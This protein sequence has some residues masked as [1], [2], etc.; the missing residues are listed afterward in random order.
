[1]NKKFFYNPALIF[2]TSLLCHNSALGKDISVPRQPSPALSMSTT[3]SK[4]TND[5]N[6]EVNSMKTNSNNAITEYSLDNGMKVLFVERKSLPVVA[7]LVLYHVGSRNEAVGHTG[8]T[9]FL[10]HLMFKGSTNYDN[11]KGRSID[12][13]LKPIGGTNSATTWFD[14]TTYFFV[15]PSGYLDLCLDMEVD[16]MRGLLLRDDDRKSEMTVVRNE[17]ERGENDPQEVLVDQLFATAFRE[18]PYHHPTIGWRSDVENVPIERFRQFYNTFYWPNNATLIVVGNFDREQA[19]KLIKEKFSKIP[20]SPQPIPQVYTKEP[21][22]EGQ[23]RF[24]F[25]RGNDLE[26]IAVGFRVPEAKHQDS[27]A[28][29]VLE[30]ILGDGSSTASRLYTSMIKTGLASGAYAWHPQLRD[31]S[32]FIFCATANEGVSPDKLEQAVWAQVE[33]LQNEPVTE[34][35]LS[36]AKSIICKKLVLDA[37]DPLE[38]AE[39]IAESIAAVSWQW[40]ENYPANIQK[41]TAGDIMQVAKKYFKKRNSTIGY[42]LPDDRS[43]D[44]TTDTKAQTSGSNASAEASKQEVAT[45]TGNSSNATGPEFSENDLKV[46]EGIKLNFAQQASTYKLENGLTVNIFPIKGLGCATVY[47]IGKAGNYAALPESI[48]VTDMLSTII[49]KGT[50]KYTSEQIGDALEQMGTSLHFDSG[51]YFTDFSSDILTADLPRYLELL[52]QVLCHPTLS[53][54]EF[55]TAKKLLNSYI[56][57]NANDTALMAQ[58]ALSR[59][60][61]PPT[62]PSYRPTTQELQKQLKSLKLAHIQAFHKKQ[63]V[64]NNFGITVVGD[65]E[66]DAALA[67]IKQHFGSWHSGKDL[68]IETKQGPLLNTG[69]KIDVEIKDKANIDVLIGQAAYVDRGSSDYFA[70]QIANGVFGFDSFASRLA[71]LREKYGY[72]YRVFSRFKDPDFK[73]E[74]WYISFSVNPENA[75]KAISVAGNLLKEYYQKGM[76]QKELDQEKGRLIGN[77]LTSLRAPNA[78]AQRLG[79]AIALGLGISYLDSYVAKTKQVTLEQA[80]TAVRTYLNP[81][82]MV[83][84]VSGTISKSK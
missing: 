21:P 17:L 44:E 35:E 74:P 25:H 39:Q 38:Y 50:E 72:C 9:H 80:N 82:N 1:M 13:V 3:N 60:I 43:T 7:T 58:E 69:K 41:V 73:G 79:Q 11:Y 4:A 76:S 68:T 77:Y 57:D 59:S 49:T 48:L 40:G 20:A 33:K 64:P 10:E 26:R 65:I 18:H 47:G 30:S 2:L 15:V 31:P 22:Q 42:A 28:L 45:D 78:I 8:S 71:E 6:K 12:A 56:L 75:N 32:L 61:Y 23:R 37:A 27:Y 46:L 24:E 62:S 83:T 84:V 36:R 29:D 70:A 16:R 14:R 52:S 54:S 51:D 19:L 67:Q 55:N 81:T 5:A 34:Q 63:F 53:Q 66:P